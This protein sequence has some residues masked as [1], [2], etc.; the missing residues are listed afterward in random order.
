MSRIAFLVALIPAVALA[1]TSNSLLDI[2]SDGKLLLS[3]NNDSGTVT[4][5]DLTTKKVLREVKVGKKPEG[6]TFIGSTH[7]AA[8]TAYGDDTIVLFNADSG[9]TL[10][11]V[12]VFDEPYGI[13]SNAEGT[14]L[15]ATLEY[16]GQV[17]EIDPAKKEILRTVN[18]GSML[19]G[20]ALAPDAKRLYVTEYLT[21]I[22]RAV[23]LESGSVVD[24]WAPL[25]PT[26]NLARQIAIHPQRPKAYVPHIRSRVTLNQGEG[27]VIPF[28]AVLDTA[29]GEGTRRNALPMDAFHGT[30]VV[31][32]P[33]EVALS[34]D[35][36]TLVAAFAGT[37]DLYVTKVLDDNY[38]ELDFRR[39]I[40]VGH[41]PRAVKFSPDGSAFYVY[42]VLDFEVTAY[43][44]SSLEKTG[45]IT[46][47]ENPLSPEVHRGK[48]LFYTALQP[49]VG[50]R[51]ISCSS[52][53]PDGDADGR[54]WQNPEGLRNTTA[55]Y[56]MAWTHPLHWSADRDET[57]DFEHTIRGQL[58]Q[59]RGLVRG[60]IDDALG[61]P[62]KG[63]SPDLDALA[64]YSNQH[65]TAVSP[66]AKNGL[67]DAAK[68]GKELF[69]SEATGCAKCHSD[70]Y[71][72]D[73]S[74]AKPYKLH[75][76]GTGRGDKSEK[77]GTKYDT[78]SLL[79]VYRTAPYLHDGTAATLMDVLT[80]CNADDQH[81]KT[82]HLQKS[83]LDDLVEFLK[84]LPYEDPEPAAKSAGLVKIE[85]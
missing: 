4:V 37:D 80:T 60:R 15:W 64:A 6:V 25:S 32:N 73:S 39:V 81:G 66:H 65:K 29:P 77:M 11:K 7:T 75:D 59:G 54:T 48:V 85:N 51:W 27:S 16:P 31:A 20:I 1:G 62:L 19:R 2:S 40:R 53:H 21:G 5:V 69:F 49:M 61:A 10:G 55:L 56:G 14:R 9:E 52:C 3:A 71:F 18:A 41:N 84:A 68:R 50:R 63:R 79:N 67:S 83:E 74:P 28:V 26:D 72:C 46:V 22:A 24:T 38:R 58:M 57:Q 47:C 76:V 78:P 43:D 82:S 30:F 35:G 45:S 13:V 17:I 12:D 44:A 36:N 8:A 33:W 23:D 34:P 70:P 42:N